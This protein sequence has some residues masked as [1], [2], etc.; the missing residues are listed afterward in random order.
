MRQPIIYKPG[1]SD[2]FG[3]NKTLNFYVLCNRLYNITRPP[4]G[5][6]ALDF[7]P[8]KRHNARIVASKMYWLP[9]KATHVLVQLPLVSDHFVCKKVQVLV[10][11]FVLTVV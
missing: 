7:D 3:N 5:N 2:F 6:P 10:L 8:V 9:N 1:G 4:A 11:A